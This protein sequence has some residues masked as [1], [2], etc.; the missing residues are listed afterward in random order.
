VIIGYNE[1]KTI[2]ECIKSV[3]EA[4]KLINVASEVVFVD[5]GSTDNSIEI[6]RQAGVDVILGGDK[7]RR[8]AENRNLGLGGSKGEFVQFIDGDMKL[9]RE[10]PGSALAFLQAHREV[11]AVC[12]QIVETGDGIWD[13]VFEIDWDMPA[14]DVAW[15]GGAAMFRRREIVSLQGF[16][17]DVSYG[18][19]PWLCWRIRN[20]LGLS[21]HYLNLPMVYHCLG[22]ESFSGYWARVVRVGATYM[23]IVRKCY[24][25][26]DRLW[27]HD[28]MNN[29]MWTAIMLSAVCALVLGPFSFKLAVLLGGVLIL[30]RKSWQIALRGHSFRVAALYSIHIYFAKIALAYGQTR[31]LLTGKRTG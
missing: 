18:E 20:E 22:L 31:Q 28:V 17:E 13:R 3:Q 15:C 14:G 11:A 26:K 23:E 21:I 27:F 2:G 9:N 10:W 25:T 7:R 30:G 4:R 16:P 1:G 5:G 12:G 29:Y 6:A 19:E 24:R 8:A